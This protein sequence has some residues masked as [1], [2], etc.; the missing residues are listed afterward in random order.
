MPAKNSIIKEEEKNVY[1]RISDNMNMLRNCP[2]CP[3]PKQY[4]VYSSVVLVAQSCLTLCV[5]MDCSPP[6]SSVHGILLARILGWIAM[7]SS[8]ISSWPRDRTWVSCIAGRLFTIWA[9]REA[10][11][12]NPAT[13][14]ET[15]EMWVQSLCQR[16]PLEE[17]NAT[18]FSILTWKIPWTEEP[19]G[20]WSRGLQRVRYD[21]SGWA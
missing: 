20:L 16:D 14:Q 18:H 7:L 9:T 6:G 17:G 11:V 8:K 5:P 10:V 2:N 3:K 1:W 21:W 13:M 12:K 19:G 15:Q 4:T